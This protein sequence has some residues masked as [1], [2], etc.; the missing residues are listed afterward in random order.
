M[1]I[2][3]KDFIS[4]EYT[5]TF[6]DGT[7]FDTT[8]E[9][10]AKDAGV[11]DPKMTYGPLII[12][13]GEQHV[14]PKLDESLVGKDAGAE[15]ELTLAPEDA[16]GKKD[17]KL[18]KLMPASAFKQHKVN[19]YPGLA[20][21]VDG[22]YGIIKTASGGRCLVDFNHPFSGK[23]VTYK[24]KVVAKVD[25]KKEQLD[26]LMKRTMQLKNCEIKVDGKKASI[27][28]PFPMPEEIT[29]KLKE[30]FEEVVDADVSFTAKQAPSQK[31][32]KNTSKQ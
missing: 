5:G 16:F 9:Q 12:C 23:T 26:T 11:H 7:V 20:V 17:A 2:K 29:K 30:K 27:E 24:L 13:V 1:A 32:E 18:V 10:A 4:L 6:E 14:L 3:A 15:Y 25:D 31:D 8:N 22:Q 19:P 21:Q 28:L